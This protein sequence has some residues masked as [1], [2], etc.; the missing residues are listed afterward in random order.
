[1]KIKL[2]LVPIF[3]AIMACGLLP[4]TTPD[5]AGHV[6]ATLTAI[7]QISP[8]VTVTA[9]PVQPT[10]TPT[11]APAATIP[12]LSLE[13]LRHGAYTSA[14]WGQFQLTDGIY[15]RTPPTTLESPEA[16]T[17]RMLDLV[18]YGDL[19]GDEIEDAIVFLATQNG[20][21]GHFVEMAAVLNQNGET[22][23]VAML[24]LGDRVV[25]EAGNIQGGV[26]TLNLRVH[27]PNDGLCCPSQSAIR[28]Y[29]LDNQQFVQLP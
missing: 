28:T 24:F 1:M 19:N 8:V 22:S 9:A 27:G 12:T 29:R 21:T 4:Q 11:A 10:V 23:N 20:G 14:D 15:Y 16:Y 2:L 3:L 26:I 6:N 17:T 13:Q 5:L 18:L 7:A 25:V